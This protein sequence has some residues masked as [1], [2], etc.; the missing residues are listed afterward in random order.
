MSS[1]KK[2]PQDPVWTI[3][4][5]FTG[6]TKDWAPDL[7]SL[8]Y[9]NDNYFPVNDELAVRFHKNGLTVKKRGKNGDSDLATIIIASQKLVCREVHV[10]L[11]KKYWLKIEDLKGFADNLKNFRFSIYKK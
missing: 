1:V 5:W 10:D 3:S 4:F 7:S 8:F 6:K 11:G 2:D 9:D